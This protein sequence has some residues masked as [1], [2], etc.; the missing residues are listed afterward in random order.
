QHAG[1][2]LC[3]II[4][5]RVQDWQHY[6]TELLKFCKQSW[7]VLMGLCAA[8]TSVDEAAAQKGAVGFY[9]T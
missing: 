3:L 8:A 2:Q 9:A 4:T 1:S 6:S 5:S 7:V